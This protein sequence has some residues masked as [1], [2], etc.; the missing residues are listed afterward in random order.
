MAQ[1][2]PARSL[3]L[4]KILKGSL[5]AFALTLLVYTPA[6]AQITATSCSVSEVSFYLSA[7]SQGSATMCAGRVRGN[8]S[9]QQGLVTETM[10]SWGYTGDITSEKVETDGWGNEGG[11]IRF[12]DTYTDFVL[13]LKAG[14]GFSL[15]RFTGS[16]DAFSYDLNRRYGLSHFTVYTDKRASVPEPGTMLLLGTGL[17]GL[18]AVRRR[19]EDV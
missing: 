9:N 17:L 16:A 12:A 7:V 18:V 1:F 15:F 14:N 2:P 5:A 13:A 8:D 11:P 6:S 4:I 3:I 10:R 19:E